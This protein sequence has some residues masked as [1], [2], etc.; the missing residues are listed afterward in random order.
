[1]VGT[2]YSGDRLSEVTFVTPKTFGDRYHFF[3]DPS[4]LRKRLIWVGGGYAAVVAI[5]AGLIVMRYLQYKMHPDDAAQYSGMWAGGD[6]MLELFICG[7]FWAM[8]FVLVLAIFRSESAYTVYSKVLLGLSVTLPLS[9]A[10]I[11]IPQVS[12]GVSFVGWACLFRV[13]A[14]PMVIF[15]LIMS[16]L[17]A[18]FP[19]PRKLTLYALVI[20]GLTMVL[21]IGFLMSPFRVHHG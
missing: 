13:F 11:A 15:G 12:E 6:L 9:V 18:R 20:E 10:F 4:V 2:W 17:F 8:T 5:S 21:M 14:S 1:V 7:M 16:L 19:R 3:M